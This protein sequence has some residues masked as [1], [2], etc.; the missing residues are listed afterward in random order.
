MKQEISYKNFF[1]NYAI[2]V[3]ITAAVFGILIYVIK[4]S[5]KSWDKNL[6]A[7]I[8]YTLEEYEPDTWEIGK[9]VK[10]AN[11]LSAGSACYD[12]RN[13]KSGENGKAVIIRV[14]TFYGPHCGVFLVLGND[15]VEF[16]GYSSLHGRVSQQLKTS[17]SSRRV[18][19]W[20]RRIKE[21]LK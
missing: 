2:F 13:K 3:L 16:K 1:I 12:A 5:Q 11:P 17:Y 7:A 18:E 8:E 10:I 21:M 9:S 19:Y 6:K 20:S 14:Q 15:K 4:V